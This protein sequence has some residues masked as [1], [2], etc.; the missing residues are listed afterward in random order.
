M[1][2]LIFEIFFISNFYNLYAAKK[3]LLRLLIQ[4][5]DKKHGSFVTQL[6][7]VLTWK[8]TE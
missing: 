7:N 3:Y 6:E 8:E 2:V 4:A 1:I 5:F